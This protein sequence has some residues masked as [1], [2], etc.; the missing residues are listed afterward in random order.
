MVGECPTG[1][2]VG[3]R[4]RTAASRSKSLMFLDPNEDV[5]EMLID[6]FAQGRGDANRTRAAL[7]R[8]LKR[9]SI[10]RVLE[11]RQ[12]ICMRCDVEAPAVRATLEMIDGQVA[13]REIGGVADWR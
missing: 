8:A 5:T 11:I 13:L 2:P 4:N 10:Y 7:S 1:T 3:M 6:S 9:V 12:R